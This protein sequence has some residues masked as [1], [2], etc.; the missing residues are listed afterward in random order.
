MRLVKTAAIVVFVIFTSGCH[1]YNHAKINTSMSDAERNAILQR[2]FFVGMPSS[3]IN[4]K[5]IELRLAENHRRITYRPGKDGEGVTT[6]VLRDRVYPVGIKGPSPG[7]PLTF[8]IDEESLL[9][10]VT[11]ARAAEKWSEVNK[12]P[13]YVIALNAYEPRQEPAP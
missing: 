3:E 4:E 7:A 8:V 13:V 6:V 1:R 11:F 10:R 5:L 2:S 12:Q 9:T